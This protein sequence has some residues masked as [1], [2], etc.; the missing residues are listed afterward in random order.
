MRRYCDLA[1]LPLAATCELHD[2]SV[3][4]LPVPIQ[5]IDAVVRICIAIESVA[6]PG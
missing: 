4:L 1:G 5:N 2:L 3:R 6:G